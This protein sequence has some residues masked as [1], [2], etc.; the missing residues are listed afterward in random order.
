MAKRNKL[1]KLKTPVLKDNAELISEYIHELGMHGAVTIYV[2]DYHGE[3]PL[4]DER[5]V[6]KSK[7]VRTPESK[8]SK[9]LP[10]GFPARINTV[11]DSYAIDDLLGAGGPDY[12][13]SPIRPIIK[14]IN[15]RLGR[16][17]DDDPG[18]VHAIHGTMDQLTWVYDKFL[19]GLADGPQGADCDT[20]DYWPNAMD[21]ADQM[22]RI[23]DALNRNTKQ[24]D[25]LKKAFVALVRNSEEGY[26][27]DVWW[28]AWAE[29]VLNA[30]HF[31]RVRGRGRKGRIPE[32][33]FQN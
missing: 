26:Y 13:S 19:S 30:P 23:I 18:H 33:D 3:Y 14:L 17:G 11:W 24:L 21:M 7:R 9:F 27:E 28:P 6:P 8:Y 4:P 25:K 32:D 29:E 2:T 22:A 31:K 12:Q 15:E 20:F 1:K 5:D 10:P 16:G